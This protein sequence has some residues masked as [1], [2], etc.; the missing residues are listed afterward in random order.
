MVIWRRR[1][2]KLGRQLAARQLD[3]RGVGTLTLLKIIK[4]C[5]ISRYKNKVISIIQTTLRLLTFDQARPHVRL[6]E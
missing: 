3:Q 4:A 6:R 5:T 2:T 1:G